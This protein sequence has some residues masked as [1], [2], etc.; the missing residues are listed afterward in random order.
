MQN[1]RH[2]LEATPVWD[3]NRCEFTVFSA[4][5]ITKPTCSLGLLFRCSRTPHDIKLLK[6]QNC[7]YVRRSHSAQDQRFLDLCDEAGILVLEESLGWSQGPHHFG[8]RHYCEL[9]E[10][11]ARATLPNHDCSTSVSPHI[12]KDTRCLRLPE[13]YFESLTSTW[14]SGRVT[15]TLACPEPI[16]AG[17][18]T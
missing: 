17:L 18:E 7:N 12:W 14:T 15:Q 8:N 2:R 9:S 6:M 16:K 4:T 13:T 11:Q 1:G 10:Q 5:T 3:G